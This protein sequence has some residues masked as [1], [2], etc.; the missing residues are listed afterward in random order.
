MNATSVSIVI[1]EEKSFRRSMVGTPAYH[2]A[3]FMYPPDPWQEISANAIDLINNFLWVQQRYRF[4]S[5]KSLFH[6]WV[7]NFHT[8]LELRRLE[9]AVGERYL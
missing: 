4:T 8:W 2:N 9:G 5:G 7:E 1:I 3:A 6:P